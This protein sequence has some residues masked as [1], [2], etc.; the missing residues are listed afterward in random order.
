M[1]PVLCVEPI[2]V[3]VGKL[4]HERL[5]CGV[6]HGGRVAQQVVVMA[7]TR[8]EVMQ[9]CGGFGA[10]CAQIPIRKAHGVFGKRTAYLV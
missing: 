2:A 6:G 9:H 3:C 1:R 8:V 10:I 5:D 7:Q 4:P